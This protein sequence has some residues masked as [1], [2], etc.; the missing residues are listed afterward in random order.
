MQKT[1]TIIITDASRTKTANS[2]NAVTHNSNAGTVAVGGANAWS[3]DW[4]A[5]VAGTGNVT[6]YAAV[7]V[8]N[9]LGNTSGDQIY[10]T[11][12]SV[13]E[14][15]VGLEEM[16]AFEDL[17]IFPNP[18]SSFIHIS[19]NEVI[20][21]LKIFNVKGQVILNEVQPGLTINV[22][23]LP[24]GVYFVQLSNENNV[25]VKRLLIQ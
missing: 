3:F 11:S 23:H 12:F 5:P 16:V 22:Q 21:N 20:E 19:T 9:G 2:G 14:G 6:F 13:I 8:T 7:N 24:A 17:K 4:T 25:S 10:T 18:T 1:G 15:G